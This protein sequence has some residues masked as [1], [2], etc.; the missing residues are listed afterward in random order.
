MGM[1]A[2]VT[3]DL[4]K[5]WTERNP[6]RRGF[7]A[8]EYAIEAVV[9]GRKNLQMVCSRE[10]LGKSFLVDQQLRKHG[11]K[12]PHLAPKN[13]DAF[14]EILWTYSDPDQ[15]PVLVIDDNDVLAW[16]ERVA[17]MFKTAFAPPH[18]VF[19]Q[20][21]RS[22][23]SRDIPPEFPFHG[24]LIWL[25]NI[26]YTDPAN[27]DKEMRVHWRAMQ[28][29]G[30][31]PIWICPSEPEDVFAY[32]V[33]LIVERHMLRRVEGLKGRHN[34]AAL[35]WLIEHRNHIKQMTPRSMVDIAKMFKDY[36]DASKREFMLSLKL[37]EGPLREIPE[38]PMKP[39]RERE[40]KE[41]PVW[42]K[43]DGHHWQNS[44]FKPMK[45]GDP[46]A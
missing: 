13:D 2:S 39:I 38:F 34:E 22:M 20:T 14:A 17:N 3:S 8:A 10:G 45:E 19:H 23:G 9:E 42:M 37:S 27:I 40:K 28:D 29:R 26:N 12:A 1:E 24:R 44:P 32:I 46:Q 4:R 36:P 6:I 11:I 18:T 33:W 16:S 41:P 30:L 35:N 25:S 31:D 21:R 43:L 15:Y 7:L 5:A